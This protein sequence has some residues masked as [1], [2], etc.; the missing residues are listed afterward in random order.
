MADLNFKVFPGKLLCQKCSED[1]KSLRLWIQSGD[2]TWM[3]T[4][5]H[6]SKVSLLQPKMKK[7]DFAN[8]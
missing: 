2:V 6:V 7:K 5:K 4:K 8:E 3:C 1:V